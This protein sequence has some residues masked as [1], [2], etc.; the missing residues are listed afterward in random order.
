MSYCR[1]SSDF[2]QCDVY[3]YEDVNGGW[4]THVAGR[5]MKHTPPPEL[6]A[7]PCS[8]GAEWLARHLAEEAWRDSLPSDEIPCTYALPGG[9]SKPGTMKMLKDSEYLAL[10][11]IG[12]EAGQSF[13][14][15]TPLACAERLEALKAKGFNVPQ[16]AI[17]ALRSEAA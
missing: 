4:T 7:M 17:D 1:W 15:P 11:T 8:T 13:S 12:V 3:V 14:D 9:G 6:V 10:A 16:S 2:W 5:R